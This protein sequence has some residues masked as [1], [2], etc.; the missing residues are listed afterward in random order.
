[1]TALHTNVYQITG[2]KAQPRKKMDPG[3]PHTIY[4]IKMTNL[5]E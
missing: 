3:S 2:I 4:N 5:K 1:M